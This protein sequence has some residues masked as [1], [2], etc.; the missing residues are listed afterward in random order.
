MLTSPG[1]CCGVLMVALICAATSLC[2][3]DGASNF[4]S[5]TATFNGAPLAGVLVTAYTTNTSS[6]YQT[7]TTDAN[8]SYSFSLPAWNNPTNGASADYHIWAT[9]PGYSFYPSAPAGA[10]VTRA[11]HTDDFAGNRIDDIPMYLT[12]IH[13][14][15]L[16]NP[17]NL[18]LPGPPLP[19]ANFAAYDGT[20]PLVGVVGAPAPNRFTDNQDGTVTDGTTGLIWL[21]NAGCLGAANWAGA[22]AQANALAGGA[23]GLADGSIAGQ[24]RLPDINELESVLDYSAA[25]PAITAGSPLTNVSN[26]IYWSSTSYFGGENGSPT[27]WAIRL[28]DGRYINDSVSNDK[29]ASTNQVWAV[30]GGGSGPTMVQSTGIYVSYAPGD[31]GNLQRGVPLPSP[32]LPDKGDGTVVDAL[33]GLVWLKQ[34]DCIHQPWAGAIA[35]VKT[36]AS[37]QCGLT[38]GSTAGSWRVPSR[39]EMQSLSDRMQSNEADFFDHTFIN[40]DGTLYQAAAFNNFISFQYYWTSTTD[41][42]STNMAWTVFSCDFGVYDALKGDAGYTL[43]VRDAQPSAAPVATGLPVFVETTG[44]D[45]QIAAVNATFPA[46]FEATV[47]DFFGNG[48][49]G[50]R[51]VFAAP[52]S[53]ASG[54]FP[55]Y[56]SAATAVTDS[57]GVATSPLFAATGP[58][59]Q[60]QVT[61]SLAGSATQALFNVASLPADVSPVIDSVG[62]ADGGPD[63]AQNTWIAIRGANLAPVYTP[64]SGVVWS[65]APDFASGLMPTQ[66]PGFPVTVTVNQK[67]AYVYFFC[68]AATSS[69]PG[70]Q[71]NVL[72]PLDSTVGPVE[73]VV[74]VGGVSS[75]P[76]NLN[77]RTVAPALPLLPSTQYAVAT[78]AD[79][80]LVGPASMSVPGY[81]YS[82]ARPGETISIYGF[83]FGM[84]A[85]ALVSDSATQSGSLPAMPVVQIGGVP[86][87][88]AYAGVVS[89]GLYML[90]VAV[91]NGIPDGDNAVTCSYGGASVPVGIT[92]AVHR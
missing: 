13:Y 32:R 77:M 37:G 74:T 38:D 78:H 28:G 65:S 50:V 53:G 79:Y 61:A 42:A 81:P 44:G 84:P 63:I 40:N 67:P 36:L 7:T 59:G 33:T 72:T 26:A 35:A 5:G 30:K 34:A 82:P 51:V 8:G 24:W 69:C 21:R 47:R 9:K 80:S 87:T 41:A 19:G 55:A 90:N 2:A 60:F 89:P 12:V 68:S 58:N 57:N 31:D 3:S 20:N 62:V 86:A 6:I 25:N 17:K 43:A 64:A 18:N 85:T 11:D 14:I 56:G 48:V 45:N 16:P 52:A 4:V 83:G 10:T 91:P 22:L 49:S 15:A 23:C 73:L 75:A 27:A 1:R 70:D 46:A 39:N 54:I 76:F 66:L 88:V 29:V 71:I 92:I